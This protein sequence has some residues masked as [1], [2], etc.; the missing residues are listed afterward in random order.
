MM[1]PEEYYKSLPRKIIAAGALVRNKEG[2]ILVLLTTYKSH[3][4][5]PGGVVEEGEAPTTALYR[6]IKEELGLEARDAR[7][8]VI[9]YMNKV[10][11]KPESIQMLYT[12]DPLSDEEISKIN[13]A[14]GE[15]AEYRFVDIDEAHKL[16]GDRIG[17]RLRAGL[18]AIEKGATYYHERTQE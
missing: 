4:E 8:I 5:I 3:W 14:D 12:I 1:A 7:P 2:K 6:E 15:I 13:F 18:K 17:P 9:E 11:N 10:P 16:V